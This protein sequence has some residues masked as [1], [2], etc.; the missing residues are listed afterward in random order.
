MSDLFIQL[1]EENLKDYELKIAT[2]RDVNERG[3]QIS[4]YSDH[5]YPII[6]ALIEAGVIGDFRA[7][8]IMRFGFTP[9][10]LK[11]VDIWDAVMILKDIMDNE[12][13]KKPEFNEISA[14]T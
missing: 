2:P 14:V 6:K 12:K 9:L 10:Y 4:L 7:P 13:W 11:Y 5:G 3:S 8:D 1:V